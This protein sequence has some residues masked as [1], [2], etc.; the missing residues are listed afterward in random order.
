MLKA[1]QQPQSRSLFKI[2]FK[3][4]AFSNCKGLYD[5]LNMR[6]SKWRQIVFCCFFFFEWTTRLRTVAI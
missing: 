6:L 3:R 5:F 1:E 4:A 2:P